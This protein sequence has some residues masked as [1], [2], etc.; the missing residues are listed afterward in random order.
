MMARGDRTGPEGMGP[1]TGRS[2]GYCAGYG[3][4]GYANAAPAM[5]RGM[6]RRFG[7][8]RGGGFRRRFNH[9]DYMPEDIAPTREEELRG[10]KTQANRLKR[11]LDDVQKRIEQLEKENEG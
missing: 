1:M 7:Y 8:G 3:M 9:P 2:M 6:A 5:G 4:P 11:T 10:L